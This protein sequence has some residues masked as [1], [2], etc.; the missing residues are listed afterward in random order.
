MSKTTAEALERAIVAHPSVFDCAVFERR[1]TSG[2]AFLVAYIAPAAECTAADMLQ[3]LR[4]RTDDHPVPDGLS[5]VSSIPLSSDG[6]PNEAM[7]S[8][9]AFVDEDLALSLETRLSSSAECA[10][11]IAPRARDLARLHVSDL[12]P[13][14]SRHSSSRAIATDGDDAAQQEAS[15]VTRPAFVDGGEAVVC[16]DGPTTLPETLLATARSAGTG[17]IFYLDGKGLESEQTYAE[18]MDAAESLL[19]GLRAQGLGAGDRVLFQLEKTSD[20]LAAF[21]GA[22]LGGMIPIPLAVPASYKLPA[23]INALE[24]AYA[25]T[26]R[27]FVLASRDNHED[28]IHAAALA[29]LPGFRSAAIEDLRGKSGDPWHTSQPDDLALLMLTSGSTGRPKAVRLSHRNLLARTLG[30]ERLN[31][32]QEDDVS[33]N[34]M[35]LDHVAG[36]IYFHI[37]DTYLGSRQIQ[38]PT[39]AV[40][41]DPLLWL[42]A[43]DRFRVTTTFAPNFAYGLVNDRLQEA[44]VPEW[45]LSSVRFILNGAEAIVTRTARHF[46]RALEPYGLSPRCMHPA[47]GMSETSSGVTYSNRFDLDSTTDDDA[48]V[49]VG[50]PI[51]GISM[52]IV[53]DALAVIDEGRI[54]HLQVRGTVVTEGYFESPELT[55]DAF[56]PDGWFETGDL[57][58]LQEG[59]LTIT[60]REKDV[61]VINSIKYYSHAIESAVEDIDGVVTSFTAACPVRDADHDTD[62][63]AIFFQP[64]SFERAFLGDLLTRIRAGIA[65]G[66]GVRPDFLIPVEAERIP[67]TSLGKIQRSELATKL[68]EGAFDDAL[69]LSDLATG[70][71]TVPHWFYRKVWCARAARAD[72]STTG[73]SVLIFGDE[74]GL[75]EALRRRLSRSG[76]TCIMVTKGAS[77][78]RL[79]AHAFRVQPDA[80]DQYTRLMSE[81]RA[82]GVEIG[83]VVHL[84]D[85]RELDESSTIDRE[86]LETSASL[87]CLARALSHD[88]TEREAIR[89]IVA[90]SHS[91]R[92]SDT[93]TIACDRAP[94]LGF[95][96]SLPLENPWF[97]SCHADIPLDSDFD[98]QAERLVA[99]LGTS[100]LEREL[101]FRPEGRFVARLHRVDLSSVSPRRLGF[102]PESLVLVTG[103]LGG[104]GLH[105]TRY[106]LAARGC[107]VLLVGRSALHSDS[108][109]AERWASLEKLS[110]RVAYVVADVTDRDALSKAVSHHETECGSSISAVI[111]LAGDYYE[112]LA[113]EQSH[114]LYEQLLLPRSSGTRNVYALLEQRGGGSLILSSSVASFFGGASVSAYAA[115]NRFLDA[116]AEQQRDRGRVSVLAFQ[117]SNWDDIGQATRNVNKELP[118]SRGYMPMSGEQAIDSLAA[119]AARGPGSLLVGL[120]G[121]NRHVRPYVDNVCDNL[122][123]ARS[124]CNA[125]DAHA[126][127]SEVV[128]M[129]AFDRFGVAASVRVVPITD[130]PRSGDGEIDRAALEE[131]SRRASPSESKAEA[132]RPGI[133]AE[134]AKIWEELLGVTGV[135]RDDSFFELGGDSLTAVRAQSKIRDRL[136]IDL[137]LRTLF[138]RTRLFALAKELESQTAV[139]RSEEDAASRPGLEDP[140]ALLQRIDDMSDEEVEALLSQVHDDHEGK[141]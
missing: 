133:E 98:R 2:N 34:W 44:T 41:K 45:D 24:G 136:G 28:L 58:T 65:S 15:G 27:P 43:I 139:P 16:A 83:A 130:L 37:R 38:I 67:K 1:T 60:G 22:S 71:H 127:S 134:L 32:F 68:R 82:D 106:L 101:A 25:V 141:Q 86:A 48:F 6:T 20:F 76:S 118:R 103:G 47:W 7:L 114:A 85:F 55:E 13:G 49:E 21:W 123:E 119:G 132:P 89:V 4:A 30:S 125:S 12:I 31:G 3:H 75:G 84:W 53:D 116:F 64:T 112:E 79:S 115:S 135:S 111:H 78:E 87:L 19:S 66:V 56:T 17:G 10:V 137:S 26:H 113:I 8:R 117:W 18:L 62:R 140:E 104:I 81:L 128:K 57:G 99:E 91:A 46:L 110:S 35:P 9:D 102:E 72:A 50:R 33:L 69:R 94:I 52:R 70:A 109:R 39:E 54:G 74:A 122:S 77:Y 73:S 11:I 108:E 14:W 93:D 29:E 59:R 105:V 80:T 23:A 138:E 126:R 61:V 40:L 36:L 88:Q 95:V 90:A 121:T 5:F 120:D 92:V 42:S 129:E 97:Q 107:R 63:L 100:S 51:P 96:R 124:Y 131:L